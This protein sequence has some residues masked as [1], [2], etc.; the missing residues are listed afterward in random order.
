M[1]DVGVKISICSLL[2][3]RTAYMN[4]STHNF[5]PMNAYA[6]ENIRMFNRG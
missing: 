1:L 2:S 3:G 4:E 6:S 5:L